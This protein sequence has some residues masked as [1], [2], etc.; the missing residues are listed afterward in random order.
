[1]GVHKNI[2]YD[3]FPK[4]GDLLGKDVILHFNYDLSKSIPAK[5][6]RDDSEDPFMTILQTKEETSRTILATECHY[7]ID[8]EVEAK[9][10]EVSP[11]LDKAISEELNSPQPS[12]MRE[13]S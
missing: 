13:L 2:D 10:H 1:M 9:S 3:K 5:C 4:Q 6:I 12:I 8:A 7:S 11:E